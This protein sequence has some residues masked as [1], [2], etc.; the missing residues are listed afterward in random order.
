MRRSVAFIGTFMLLIL[1]APIASA[2]S[3]LPLPAVRVIVPAGAVASVAS[4]ELLYHRVVNLMLERYPE[5][6]GFRA[7]LRFNPQ[8]T[9]AV[10]SVQC[11][12]VGR[13]QV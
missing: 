1:A 7:F 9:T 3:R 6:T 10:L 12:G 5:C 4:R 11:R 2:R 13:T 8:R